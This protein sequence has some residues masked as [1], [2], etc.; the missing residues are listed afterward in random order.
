MA[1][2]QTF[3]RHGDNTGV[4]IAIAH[5]VSLLTGTLVVLRSCKGRALCI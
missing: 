4:V 3:S 5:F 1:T 2:L